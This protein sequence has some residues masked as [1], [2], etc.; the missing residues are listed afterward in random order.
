MPQIILASCWNEF[1]LCGGHAAQ[2]DANDYFLANMH[3]GSYPW[4][5]EG[6]V[7]T[8]FGNGGMRLV[9]SS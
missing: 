9:E 8:P 4:H 6:M 2:Q 5:A 7:S 3:K 1:V